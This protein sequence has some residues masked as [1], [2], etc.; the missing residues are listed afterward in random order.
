MLPMEAEPVFARSPAAVAEAFVQ[1]TEGV[2][3][4]EE[5]DE[6]Q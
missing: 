1:Q 2:Q 4:P 6:G 3:Q 5:A